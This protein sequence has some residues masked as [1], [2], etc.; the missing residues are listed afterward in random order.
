[1]NRRDSWFLVLGFL[2]VGCVSAG[3]YR[4]Y[5]LDV[6]DGCYVDGQLIAPK[7][8]KDLPLTAC[9]PNAESAAP[10]TVFKTDVAFQLMEDLDRCVERLKGCEGQ[11]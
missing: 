1:M 10:C 5:R 11:E 3:T 7:G 2:L 8:G 6:P 4:Y 9:R